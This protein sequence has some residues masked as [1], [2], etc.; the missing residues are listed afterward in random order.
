MKTLVLLSTIL[1]LGACATNTNKENS[2]TAKH[3]KELTPEEKKIVGT[4]ELKNGGDTFRNVFLDN[5]VLEAF[6]N[7]KKC[8]EEYKWIIV[9]KEVHVEWGNG[10]VLVYR[11]NPD[12]SLT[13]IATIIGGERKDRRKEYQFIFKKSNNPFSIHPPDRL[14]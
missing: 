3:V 5:G 1:L 7:G 11:I 8:E 4:Y 2:T 12:G 10:R 9:G 6:E 13:D 14:R